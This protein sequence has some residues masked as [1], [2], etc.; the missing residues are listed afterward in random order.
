MA[1]EMRHGFFDRARPDEAQVAVARFDRPGRG[2]ASEARNMH[3]Q[4]PVAEPVVAEPRVALVDLAP[5][6]DR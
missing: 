6:T 2:E 4:L 1:L 3:V 5:S